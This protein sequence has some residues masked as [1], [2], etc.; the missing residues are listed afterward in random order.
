V[1]AWTAAVP[2]FLGLGSPPSAL[3]G[4]SPLPK[5]QGQ[6][7][8][9]VRCAAA[10]E[11][12]Q[13]LRRQDK[14]SA[15]RSELSI[16]QETCPKVLAADCKRWLA[17]VDVLM[18]TVLLRAT[19]PQGRPIDARVTIDGTPLVERWG[20]SP[21][22]VDAGEHTFR[23]ESTSGVSQE[24][25]VSLHGGE[26]AIP[27]GAVFGLS[28]QPTPNPAPSTDGAPSSRRRLPVTSIVLGVMGVSTVGAAGAL[29]LGGHVQ[30]AH[31]G[32]ACA[33]HCSPSEVET[34]ADVYD[35]AWVSAGVG[36]ACLLAALLVWRPWQTPDQASS[37]ATAGRVFVVPSPGG[38]SVGFA[39]R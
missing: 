21:V 6:G 19:D 29:T 5:G 18:P 32:S 33:P 31:L 11:Q 10:Y 7:D 25:H 8:A 26:R 28:A 34:V 35:A 22:A 4:P 16:C 38:A 1:L 15:S 9:K 30:A 23:F 3:A 2:V 37:P 36:A 24:V 13:E 12:A 14:L 17:E 20:E 27:V 39:F